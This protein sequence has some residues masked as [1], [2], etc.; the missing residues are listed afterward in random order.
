MDFLGDWFGLEFFPKYYGFFISTNGR[1]YI[2]TNIIAP[3]IGPFV[4]G[5]HLL[6]VTSKG[7]VST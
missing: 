6:T 5:D 2:H 1:Y 7:S 4:M 3:E